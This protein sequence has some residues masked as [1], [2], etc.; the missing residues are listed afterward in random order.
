MAY[1]LLVV[2]V[3]IMRAPCAADTSVLMSLCSEQEQLLFSLSAVFY[4]ALLHSPPWH[5][6]FYKV[7]EVL[8]RLHAHG[9]SFAT[10]IMLVCL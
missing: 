6:K 9:I 10:S 3:H 5:A 7:A 2:V 8:S 4:L 1:M